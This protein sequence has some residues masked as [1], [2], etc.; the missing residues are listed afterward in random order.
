MSG[1][2]VGTI[3]GGV[4]GF[5]IGGPVGAQIGAAAGG[6]I[7]GWISPTQVNGPRPGDGAAQSSADGQ[8]IPW[9]LGTAGWIQG[10]ISQKSARRIVKKTDD[11]KGSGTEVN[12]YEAHQDFLIL[13]CESSETRNSLMAGCLMV[14]VDGKVVYD[15]RPES[16]FAVDNAKFLKNHTF[17]NGNEAQL[18]DPTMEAITGVGRTLPYRGVFTMVARDINLAPYGDRIPQ[19]EFVMAGAGESSSATVTELVPPVYGRFGNVPFPLLDPEGFYTFTGAR[20]VGG[21]TATFSA[22]TIQEIIAHFNALGFNGFASDLAFYSGYSAGTSTAPALTNTSMV[23]VQPD[24]TDNL[25]VVLVYQE[26]EPLEW[27]NA[28]GNDASSCPL[29]PYTF[30][31]FPEWYGFKDGKVG[32]VAKGTAPPPQYPTFNNCTSYPVDPGTGNFPYIQGI[33]PL[34][35]RAES[36]SSPPSAVMG[37][38]C[39][40][41]VPVVLPDRPEYM[42]DCA[43]NISPSP[44]YTVAVGSFLALQEDSFAFIAGRAQYT[45]RTVGPI[46]VNTDP[47]GTEAFWVAAYDAAV[48]AGTM[49]AGLVYGVDY[50]VSISEVYQAEYTTSSLT[51]DTLTVA[52]AITRISGRSGVTAGQIDVTEMTQTLLGYPIMQPYNGADCLRP[53]MT[54]HTSFGSEY[55]GKVN[56]HKHGSATDLVV[57]PDDFIEGSDE[58]EEDTRNQP[59]EYPRL[60]SVRAIDPTMDYTVRPQTERRLSPDVR[61]LGES[62]IDLSVVMSPEASRELAAIGMKVQ[63]AR[64]QGE[65]KFSVPFATETATYLEMV[66]GATFSL[67]NKRFVSERILL[68]DG[69]I[70]VHGKYDRQSAYTAEVTPIPALPPA[71]PPS[72]I[73]GVTLFA[74]MNL[75]RL[76]SQDN[77]PGMYMAFTGLLP[78]WPGAF[79]QMSTDDGASWSTVIA[80]ATAPSVIGYLRA[81]IGTSPAETL[82]VAIFGGTLNS[83]SA[84]A[85]ADGGNPV[86]VLSGGVAEIMQF[87]DVD[88]IAADDYDLTA[89]GRGRLGTT[90][91]AHAI[92][93]RFTT[94]S[95]VYF[96]PLDISLAGREILFRPVTFNTAPDSNAIYPVTFLPQFTGPQVIEAYVNDAGDPYLNE[97]GTPYYRTSP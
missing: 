13:I 68:K 51:T 24:V 97:S 1:G 70:E 48:L 49:D 78:A 75:P 7:G 33:F 27:F 17:Y 15:M 47:I 12:T 50:P 85:F 61:A 94:L 60:F 34:Y 74:A 72:S 4:A 57:N 64:Q 43:G 77:S 38:P 32:R 66:A 2:Q 28:S 25:S 86:A 73:G 76:R 29:M 44:V 79:L 92:G 37:D 96:V 80:S 30:P 89:L 67:Y 71:R 87:R 36:R 53:L 31:G 23:E 82:A 83:I 91:A 18:P 3:V 54:A 22:D 93:D 6:M 81:A 16:N 41:G 58:I 84:A 5:F 35:I 90:P 95:S 62:S 65:V 45:Q 42:I 14:R 59:V 88:E 55:D 56:F 26:A 8:P 39:L 69:E 11:G 46:I 40:L 20:E 10:N 9:I 63:W 21:S 19:Y 52:T